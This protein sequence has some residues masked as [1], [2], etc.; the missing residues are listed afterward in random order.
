MDSYYAEARLDAE[1]KHR[2]WLTG[3][4][5]HGDGRGLPPPRRRPLPPPRRHTPPPPPPP[6][7]SPVPHRRGDG[8][9]D[10]RRGG[11]PAEREAATA[12]RAA[13]GGNAA[14]VAQG[15]LVGEAAPGASASLVAR[16]EER[17]GGGDG[18]VG[19]KRRL[20]LGSAAHPPP[21]RRALCASARRQFPPG[22]GR[23]ANASLSGADPRRGDAGA[24][25]CSGV[26]ENAAAAPPLAGGKDGALSDV[27]TPSAVGT[28]AFTVVSASVAD[29][30]ISDAG[31][32]GPEADVEEGAGG[33]KCDFPPGCGKD[34]VLSLLVGECIGEVELPLESADL[35]D[36]DLGVAE[37]VVSTSGC[38]SM[39]HGHG[40]DLVPPQR[41]DTT[42]GIVQDDELEEGEIPPEVAVHESQ[43][44]AAKTSSMQS[45]NEICGEKRSTCLVAKEVKVMNESIGSSCDDVTES[46]ADDSSKHNMMCNRVSE[47]N[48]MNRASSDVEGV[49]CDRTTVE[50]VTLHGSTHN[51]HGASVPEFSAVETPVMQPSNEKTGRSTLQCGEKRSSGL[52]EKNVE[53]VSQSIGSPSNI[54]AESLAE[55]SCKQD[56]MGKRVF[57]SARMNRASSDAATGEFGD[58]TKIRRTDM[59]TPRKVVGPIKNLHKEGETE[60]GRVVTINRIKDTDE[61]TKDQCMQVPMSSDKFFMPQEKE[62]A[63]TRG[64]FGPRKKVKVKVPAHLRMKIGSMSALCSKG[65]RNDEVA[66]ILDDDEILKALVVHE[67]KLELYLNSS[68]DLPSMR[69]QRQYGSQ[70]AD[71]RSKFKMLCR[72]FEFVCRALVQAVEQRSL[73]IRRIDIEADKVIRKLPGFI[74]HGPIVGQVPGVEV[75]DEFIYRVQL[76]IVGLH[77]SYQGGIDTTTDR[78]GKRIAISIVASGGYPDELPRSGELIY[79]GSGGKSRG[80]KDGEDQKLERGNLALKNCIKTKTPVRVIYGFKVQNTEG[81]S[82][83]RAKQ[84][85]TFTY[86]GLYRVVDFWMHGRPGSKVFKYKLQRIP[87][88]PELPMHI[89]KGMKAKTRPS[90]CVADISQRKEAT[91]ISVVNT[92][93]GVRPTPFR[94]ITTIKYPFGLT[95]MPHQGCDCTNGC[96]DSANCTCAVK[97]GGEIPFNSNGAIVNEKPLIFECGPSCKCPPSCQNRVSQHGVKIPLEVFRTTKTGWG[98]R[99]LRSISSGSFICEYVGELLH[100]KEADK[101]RNSDYLFDVGLN[102]GDEN[103]CDGLLST[104]SGLNS[105]SSSQTIEDVGFTIDAAEYG[106]IGRFINHSCSPNL[107]TQN[108]LWDHDDKRMPH[109]MF[110]AAETIPPLQELTYDYN[111]EIDHDGEVNGRINSKVCQCGSPQCSGRLY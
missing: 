108:V 55:D 50:S 83:S 80:K 63:T 90:L 100:G 85:S 70:N 4:A 16:E 11:G 49:S 104:V 20:P 77:R 14:N 35:A 7:R 17:G 59:F 103:V 40:M 31:H 51:G 57:E 88:Q 87:G 105:S 97:N 60:H 23:H 47:S 52:V 29:G 36:G 44:R 53:V 43:V 86:D 15:D 12:A 91:P 28:S 99:S 18:E 76:A 101:R 25:G 74:K 33:A 46:L 68:S 6:R 66:S 81:S 73:K 92:V 64:F 58:G 110:F 106:N 93:D 65:K 34:A 1:R 26:L 37:E 111:Y 21:R 39:V 69:S 67:G 56:M 27:V 2:R 10:K 96:S 48:R 30:P 13:P 5:G 45:Y 42:D 8:G 62:A 38:T 78:N 22:C 79:S 94:Y 54:V 32:H 82:H 98:V 107:Y 72:R 109:I 24:R 3:P 41:N 19:S 9:G 61:L 75:G 95:K 89:A 71:A 102:R 84:I